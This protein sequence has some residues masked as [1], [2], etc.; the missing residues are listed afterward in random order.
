MDAKSGHLCDGADDAFADDEGAALPDA[1]AD[2]GIGDGMSP[3]VMDV[4]AAGED[5]PAEV[6]IQSRP[7]HDRER[8]QKSRHP[9]I[10]VTPGH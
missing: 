6:G 2:L 4:K 1:K 5:D 8:S 10:Q 3:D 9:T 7:V